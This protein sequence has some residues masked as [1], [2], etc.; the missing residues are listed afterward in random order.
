MSA[1]STDCPVIKV[2]LHKSLVPPFQPASM[3]ETRCQLKYLRDEGL[4]KP[5]HGQGANLKT[6]GVPFQQDGGGGSRHG[7]CWVARK[8]SLVRTAFA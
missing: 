7:F 6:L 1:L 2:L 5:L 8:E 3:K 4:Q